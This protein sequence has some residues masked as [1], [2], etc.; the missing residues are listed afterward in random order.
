MQ[1]SDFIQFIKEQLVALGRTIKNYFSYKFLSKTTLFH[2]PRLTHQSDIINNELLTLIYLSNPFVQ[3]ASI[4]NLLYSSELD[5]F[6]FK[7]LVECIK[8]N[9]FFIFL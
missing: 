1:L 7:K 6:D 3:E 8:G 5:T 9:L 2:L 4:L